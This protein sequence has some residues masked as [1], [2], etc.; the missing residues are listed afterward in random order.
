M[1][2]SKGATLKEAYGWNPCGCVENTLAGKTRNYT[3]YADYNL[4]AAVEFALND[5]LSRKYNRYAGARTGDPSEFKTY[6]EFL[7]AIKAQLRHIIHGLVAGDQVTQHLQMKQF[8]T[9]A[10]LTFEGCIEKALDYACGGPVMSIGDGLDAIGVAD[11][12]NSVYAVKELVYDKKMIT[13]K[14]LTDALAADFEGY[15][16]IHAMCL[17]TKKYGNDDEDVNELVTELFNYIEDYIETFSNRWGKLSGG[18]LPV[19]GNTPIGMEVGAL[20][21]GRRAWLPLAD[22]VS[23]N[24]GTDTQ[25]MSAVINSVSSIPHG[26]NDQGT[27]LNLKMDPA[28]ARGEGSVASLMSFLKSLCAMGIYHVQFNVVDENELKDAQVHPEDHKGLLIRVAGYTAFFTELSPDTQND[29]IS[30]TTQKAM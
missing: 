22:G 18:I 10:S 20:P 7:E 2:M 8:C 19:S 27:L 16:D 6:E 28:F 24:V 15:E 13:M 11:L 21:S 5:G 30:R 25:G 23:P 17:N 1:M 14:Q 26:R 29:I 3:S 12:V 4:G 9:A